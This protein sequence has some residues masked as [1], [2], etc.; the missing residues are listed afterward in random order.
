[1]RKM[2]IKEPLAEPVENADSTTKESK[3]EGKAQPKKTKKAKKKK[4]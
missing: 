2:I 1:M 3:N 4:I